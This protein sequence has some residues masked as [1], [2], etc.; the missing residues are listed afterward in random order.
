MLSILHEFSY[1]ILQTISY[2]KEQYYFHFPN[3]KKKSQRRMTYPSHRAVKWLSWHLMPGQSVPQSPLP[4]FSLGWVGLEELALITSIQ[5]PV[6]STFLLILAYFLFFQVC[7]F[8]NSWLYN[9]NP[10]VANELISKWWRWK[11]T[12]ILQEK[13]PTLLHTSSPL[14]WPHLILLSDWNQNGP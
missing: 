5:A 4:D 13:A 9:L 12:G 1:P 11:G 2:F 8:I 3:F 6:G 10:Q 14:P 7:P